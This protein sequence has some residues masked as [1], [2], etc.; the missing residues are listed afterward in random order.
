M[1]IEFDA[2]KN[3]QNIR[4]RGLSF[5]RVADFDFVTALYWR[6]ERHHYGELRRIALGHLDDRLHVLCYV[7]RGDRMRVISL[8]KANAREAKVYAKAKATD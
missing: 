2:T 5:E 6:D 1:D 3:A 8:R 7:L 4:E